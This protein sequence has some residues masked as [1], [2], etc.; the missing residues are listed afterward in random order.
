M[1]K[2]LNAIWNFLE[3]YKLDKNGHFRRKFQMALEAFA[4]ELF[5]YHIYQKIYIFCEHSFS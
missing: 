2:P 5:N 4:S 1:Q 3:I